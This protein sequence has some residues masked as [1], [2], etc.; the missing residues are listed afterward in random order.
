MK[1]VIMFRDRSGP[2][3][4]RL[5][6]VRPDAIDRR[7]RRKAA[8]RS[9]SPSRRGEAEMPHRRYREAPLTPLQDLER[10]ASQSPS[11][12]P[13]SAMAGWQEKLLHVSSTHNLSAPT[14]SHAE[15]LTLMRSQ[16]W[17]PPWA[18]QEVAPPHGSSTSATHA[19]LLERLRNKRY[20]EMRRSPPPRVQPGAMARSPSSDHEALL[21]SLRKKHYER[22][23]VHSATMIAATG[24]KGSRPR[25]S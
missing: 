4:P 20:D 10:M 23:G 22:E 11:A 21:Q 8:R 17:D 7:G 6:R 14:G 24:N 15:L 5:S 1:L 12:S 25:E 18:S 2:R 13:T 9:C 16:R 3:T 19:A